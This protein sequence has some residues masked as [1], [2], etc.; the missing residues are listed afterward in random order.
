M[1]N[2]LVGELLVFGFLG[3]ILYTYPDQDLLNSIIIEDLFSD[4]PFG[5]SQENTKKGLA[6]INNWIHEYKDK[7]EALR[8][9]KIDYTGLFIE[10]SDEN[11][12]PWE[13]VYFSEERSIFHI[14]T[15]EIREWY[16]KF[17]LQITNLYKEPDDHIGLEFAFISHLAGLAIQAYK[18]GDREKYL[19]VVK[20]QDQFFS[21]HIF[22]WV[23]KW[24]EQIQENAKTDFYHGIGYLVQGVLDEVKIV[25]N[26]GKLLEDAS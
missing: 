20:A 11:L 22:T 23:P 13:S 8:E 4:I 19:E 6:L 5:D 26:E 15:L 7:A 3:K 24:C 18:E 9:L 2:I 14:R 12:S 25:L 10:I 17:G 1:E 21:E 16:R